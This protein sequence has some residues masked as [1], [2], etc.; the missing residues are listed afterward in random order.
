M[1]KTSDDPTRAQVAAGIEA[2]NRFDSEDFHR[3]R[4]ALVAAVYRAM[5]DAVK[6]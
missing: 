1:A 3:N 2:L 6:G 4:A 5:R